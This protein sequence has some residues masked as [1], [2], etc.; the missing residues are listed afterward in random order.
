MTRIVTLG[1]SITVGM[2]NPD[3]QGGYRPWAEYLATGLPDPELH[4]LAVIGAHSLHVERFQLPAALALRPDI[5]TVSLGTCDTLWP[6]FDPW[7]T[8]QATARIVAALQAAGATVL[9][10]QLPDWTRIFG[11]LPSALAKPVQRRTRAVNAELE[12]MVAR[13]GTLHWGADRDMEIYER[14]NWSVDRMHPNDRG[15]RLIAC[16]FW[17]LLAAEGHAVVARPDPVPTSP[18]PTRRED[19]L[20]I[21][22]EGVK[23]FMRRS[24]DIVP[25]LLFLGI[26]ELL[27]GPERWVTTEEPDRLSG[28][29]ETP[30]PIAMTPEPS[31]TSGR[32]MSSSS[33]ESLK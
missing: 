21:A 12:K 22:T 28:I 4:N 1:D 33:L 23:W 19:L 18:G 17:D 11:L 25:Y 8:G 16:R 10:M 20:W 31:P 2:G 5:A 14:G 13:Y 6:G 7:G 29:A 27:A 26:R 3:G 30:E 9:T 32:A 15:Q 24:G